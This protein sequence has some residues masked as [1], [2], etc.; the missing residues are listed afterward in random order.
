MVTGKRLFSGA[1]VTEILADILRSEPPW[2]ELAGAPVGLVKILRRCLR[3]DPAE[4]YQHVGDLRLDLLEVADEVKAGVSVDEAPRRPSGLPRGALAAMA[5][6]APLVPLAFWLGSRAPGTAPGVTASDAATTRRVVRSHR[7]TATAGLEYLPAISP[8][9]EFAA[10]A[11]YAGPDGVAG[12]RQG[13]FLQRI[14]GTRR[15]EL[16]AGLDGLFTGPDFS[17]D[18]REIVFSEG[19]RALSQPGGLYR[20]GTT[21]ESRRKLLDYGYGPDW[22]PDGRTIAFST[23]ATHLPE[24]RYGPGYLHLLDLETGEVTLLNE[25]FDVADPSWSP[26]G[27]FLAGWVQR[28]G[29]RDI[30]IFDPSSGEGWL[31]TDDPAIEGAPDW[32]GETRLVF[33]S[34]RTGVMTL[35]TLEL[36]EAGRAASE[37]RPL[38]VPAERATSPVFARAASRLLYTSDRLTG[39]IGRM[40]IGSDGWPS[41]P[42]ALTE[43]D[44]QFVD[45]DVSPDGRYVSFR[46]FFPPQSVLVQA[47]LSRVVTRLVDDDSAKRYP[48]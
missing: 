2:E 15:I 40:E 16:T 47:V 9:G 14:G 13:L 1:S 44:H 35:M 12:F 25:A 28:G 3:Q 36:D 24:V 45:P 32:L 23:T 34:D 31:V 48:R 6:L 42:E 5:L 7:V 27:R 29:I 38:P 41:T 21:G 18:G 33:P 10:F 30:A 46:D 17:P 26:H 8:D 4:R 39:N 19:A 43:G 37:P 11:V 20:V 22:S